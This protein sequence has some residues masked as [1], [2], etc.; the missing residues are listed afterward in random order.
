V[1]QVSAIRSERLAEQMAVGA[2]PFGEM[3]SPAQ[4]LQGIKELM[5]DAARHVPDQHVVSRVILKQFAEPYGKKREVLLAALNRQRPASKMT[6]GGPNRYCKVLNFVNFASGS[7]EDLWQQ[8]ETKLHDV[9]EVVKRDGQVTDPVHGALIRDAIALH[10]VRSIP[11]RAYHLDSWIKHREAARQR[12]RAQP[13]LLQEIHVQRFGWWTSDPEWLERAVDWF[14]GPL[15]ALVGSDAV[16]RYSLEE[17][18]ERLRRGFQ[19]FDLKILTSGHR[20]F[21]IGDAPVLMLREGRG[22]LGTFDG[23]G[24]ANADEIVLHL[25]PHHAAVLGQGSG[26]AEA[27]ERQVERYNTLEVMIAYRDICFRP[28]SG[29]DQFVRATL[30]PD[31]P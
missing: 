4:V 9:L 28:T 22:G 2:A 18:L 7:A 12:L 14:Y 30:A 11:T 16:L 3:P 1:A 5:P 13:R 17:R 29:L 23:V 19:A 15:D 31:S 26:A 21:L 8:T 27:T 10:I 25:T 6:T 24:V 20:E